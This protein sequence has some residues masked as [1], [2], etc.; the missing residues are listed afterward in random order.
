VVTFIA[1]DTQNRPIANAP[2]Q[3]QITGSGTEILDP[4]MA[5][6]DE[7]GSVQTVV[8]SGT[9]ATTIRVTALADTNGD[10]V[11]DIAV[12]SQIVSILGAPPVI[13]RF[14]VGP[15]RKN[16]SGRILFGQQVEIGAFV[17]D[18][19]GNAVPP[20]TAVS[21]IS[22]GASVVN[23]SPTDATGQASATLLTEGEVPPSGI[24][25]VLAFTRAMGVSILVTL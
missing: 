13:N 1:R 9:R 5:F 21:F 19:F 23:P 18:R 10:A 6:T 14:S 17:N 2:V 7:S 12:Q 3:F 11:A 20:G 25:T 22:N 8:T 16:V 4:T 24:V 15:E